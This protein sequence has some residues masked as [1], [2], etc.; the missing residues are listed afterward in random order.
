MQGTGVDPWLETIPHAAGLLTLRTTTTEAGVLEPVLRNER[1][2]CD[3]K[4]M[5]GN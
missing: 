5:Q 4:P 1:R 3:E 2:H